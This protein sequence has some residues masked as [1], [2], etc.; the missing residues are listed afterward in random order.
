[1]SPQTKEVFGAVAPSDID[2]LAHTPGLTIVSLRQNKTEAAHLDE[3]HHKR[4]EFD[5]VLS[6]E[7]LTKG[8]LEHCL[9]RRTWNKIGKSQVYCHVTRNHGDGSSLEWRR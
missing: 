9:L 3:V 4:G 6:R 8:V 7:Q 2:H 1:M 5:R